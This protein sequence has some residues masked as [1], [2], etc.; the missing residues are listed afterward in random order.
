MTELRGERSPPC[1]VKQ[2]IFSTSNL[3]TIYMV[4][5]VEICMSCS[6]VRRSILFYAAGV[7]QNRVERLSDAYAKRFRVPCIC[8]V[9]LLN[10][11]AA[12]ENVRSVFLVLLDGF[13]VNY[14]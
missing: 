1:I 2:K 8:K 3:C 11:R 14:I 10:G 9:A 13:L 6:T 7:K 12:I 4:R 5:C